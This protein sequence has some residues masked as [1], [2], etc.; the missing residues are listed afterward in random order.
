MHRLFTLVRSTSRLKLLCSLTSLAGV[1]AALLLGS[2]AWQQ[3]R[4]VH[5]RVFRIG[6][7]QSPPF[8]LIYKD[9]SFGG[10]GVEMVKEAARRSGISLE[11]VAFNGDVDQA[12]S[13]GFVDLW[14]L[15][16]DLPERRAHLH[17]T[18]PWL[19]NRFVLVV[20]RGQGALTPVDF[21][22][23]RVA[24]DKI[25]INQR[26]L[27]RF[28]PGV[29]V[30]PVANK[31]TLVASLCRGEV[32]A[33]FLD[34]RNTMSQL[35]NRA[36]ECE[37][38]DLG[39]IPVEGAKFGMSVGATRRSK[40]PG[41]AAE[42][43]R[44]EITRL[45]GD[46]TMSSIYAK[47]LLT[48][49]DDTRTITDLRDSRIHSS[50]LGCFLAVLTV[51]LA[52][53]I[54]QTFRVRAARKV[55]QLASETADRANAAKSQFLANM[56]HEIRTPMNGVIGMTELVLDSDLTDDQRSCLE[57]VRESGDA[58]LLVINDI[59]D[60]SKIEAGCL[61]LDSSDFNIR[62]LLQ[63]CIR[64]SAFRAHQKGLRLGCD[65]ASDVPEMLCGDE[66]RLRQI[67]LNLVGNALKF[68]EVGDVLVSVIVETDDSK[69]GICPLHF[70]VH[71]TGIGIESSKQGMIFEA[72]AQADGSTK[73]R[74]GGTGLGLSISS[75][76]V[77]L[78]H[79]RIWVESKLGEGSTFHFTAKFQEAG[80]KPELPVVRTVEKTGAGCRT[81]PD[82]RPVDR[83][84]PFGLMKY[85]SVQ[86]SSQPYAA[87]E[88]FQKNLAAAAAPFA[89]M[90]SRTTRSTR[91]YGA[92]R[93]LTGQLLP[94]TRWS[95][96]KESQ[97]S[98][99]AAVLPEPG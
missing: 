49:A 32:A 68:T 12:L 41:V 34:M 35:L 44:K 11:W 31:L 20:R 77:S 69:S 38:T 95:G 15:L 25:A 22:G 92:T 39:L 8:N 14:P 79:G 50:V 87:F 2:T 98:S 7:N 63:D 64:I 62:K 74:F 9:G 90:Y 84:A 24:T 36:P 17:L 30:I 55:A 43:L 4:E 3:S 80:P 54:G 18:D 81:K 66:G 52:F 33:V 45:A 67:V 85:D 94:Y 6:V 13:T 37:H 23:R 21:G 65:I 76:L 89:A 96:P 61:Q 58:L 73:R 5:R 51:A 19:E 72:F 10:I 99:R 82:Q 53:S 78:F 47:W 46:G 42:I 28:V 88:F 56:S 86:R 93:S 97:S 75:Q 83:A 71:D 26:L 16:T 1:I 91:S 40:T 60:F 27:L 59:L 29:R 70:S 57:T 48:T